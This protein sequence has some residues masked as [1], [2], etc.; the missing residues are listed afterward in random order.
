MNRIPSF[1]ALLLAGL[2]GCGTNPILDQGEE[3]PEPHDPNQVITGGV[4]NRAKG[5][6]AD[7]DKPQL[8]A[9]TTLLE[10]NEHLRDLL[11]KALAARR[12]K[13]K[14]CSD[15]AEQIAALQ[16][17]Q[18]RLKDSVAALSEQLQNESTRAA[19][20]EQVKLK[21]EKDRATLA[22]MYALEKHQRL[23]FEKDLLERE[24]AERTLGKDG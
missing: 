21:L 18:G 4:E 22:R 2:F 7:K 13:E 8:S 23:E 20:L 14:E 19:D 15:L 10:E 17:E 9:R 11:A 12:D 6:G 5:E 24:I 16:K 3:A 1:A